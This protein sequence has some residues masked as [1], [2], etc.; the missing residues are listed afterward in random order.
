MI[1]S[2]LP[3]DGGFDVDD[4]RC[5]QPAPRERQNNPGA[6]SVKRPDVAKTVQMTLAGLEVVRSR[7]PA[8]WTVG[9]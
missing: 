1:I 9:F 6:E 3:N 5:R 8:G 4:A 2:G 7:V